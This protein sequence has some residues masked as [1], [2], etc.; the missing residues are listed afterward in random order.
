MAAHNAELILR[1]ILQDIEDDAETAMERDSDQVNWD[2][3]E[4]D[5][6]LNSAFT[7]IYSDLVGD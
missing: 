7:Q 6:D 5:L 2:S 1:Q 4:A 3:Q